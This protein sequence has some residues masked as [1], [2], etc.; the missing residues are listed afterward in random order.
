[1]QL[2]SF[3]QDE[4]VNFPQLIF[5]ANLSPIMLIKVFLSFLTLQWLFLPV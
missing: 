3:L 4:I 1:M 5:M 2:N